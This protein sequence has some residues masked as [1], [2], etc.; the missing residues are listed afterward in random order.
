MQ[1]AGL[2]GARAKMDARPVLDVPI[3]P[4]PTP[5]EH[6][7]DYIDRLRQIGMLDAFSAYNRAQKAAWRQ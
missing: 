2:L 7:P 6:F 3:P 5:H 4:P 1:L